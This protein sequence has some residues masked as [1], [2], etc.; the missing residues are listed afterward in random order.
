MGVS[1]VLSEQRFLCLNAGL[2]IV[3][4]SL[5]ASQEWVEVDIKG[6]R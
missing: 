1:A 3:L 5:D 2:S 6:N 4:A